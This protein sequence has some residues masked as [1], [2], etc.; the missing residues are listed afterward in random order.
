MGT[1]HARR[2]QNIEALERWETP[3]MRVLS[4]SENFDP[5]NGLT[6]EQW[7]AVRQLRARAAK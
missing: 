6:W 3:A 1:S 2:K 4:F 7:N 5:A